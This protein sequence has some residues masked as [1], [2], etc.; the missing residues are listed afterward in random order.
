[1]RLGWGSLCET[2][3]ER[4]PPPQQTLQPSSAEQVAQC[5]FSER[6]SD[7]LHFTSQ[8]LESQASPVSSLLSLLLSPLLTALSHLL[9][10]PYQRE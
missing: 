4:D 3:A 10:W 7:C 8:A 5:S 9:I 2:V 6:L 1:M